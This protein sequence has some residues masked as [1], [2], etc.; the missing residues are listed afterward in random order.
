MSAEK[1]VVQM[2]KTIVI[3][4]VLALAIGG[5]AF[6]VA[7]CGEPS[8]EEARAQLE[9]DLETL[10][11]SLPTLLNPDTYSSSEAFNE[12]TDEVQKSFD[13]V[14]E[15]AKT[16]TDIQT[17]DLSKAWDN[18]KKAIASDE[19]LLNKLD[20]IQVAAAEFT[21]AWQELYDEVTEQ[22]QQEK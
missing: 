22:L 3:L 2:R 9:T 6:A 14:I 20:S 10:K 4:L 8:P 13:D 17:E 12:A 1:G 15:S 19:P 5:A 16:V 7:G 11:D 18:L 21:D